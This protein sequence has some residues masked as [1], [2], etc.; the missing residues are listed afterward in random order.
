MNLNVQTHPNCS[1]LPVKVFVDLDARQDY[2]PIIG[3]ATTCCALMILSIKNIHSKFEI[4]TVIDWIKKDSYKQNWHP[5]NRQG[6]EKSLMCIVSPGEDS[7][8]LNLK[9]NRL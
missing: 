6:G 9:K 8:E 7:L 2:P 5:D 4:E 1:F 3:F